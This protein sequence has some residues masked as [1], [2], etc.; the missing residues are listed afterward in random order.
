MLKVSHRSKEIIY[1]SG[2]NFLKHLV[3]QWRT[4]TQSLAH[5]CYTLRLPTDNPSQSHNVWSINWSRRLSPD[6]KRYATQG[7][8]SENDTRELQKTLPF[9]T[10]L[11]PACWMPSRKD[12][13]SKPYPCQEKLPS[14]TRARNH[15]THQ[16]QGKSIQHGFTMT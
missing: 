16:K 3:F 7:P 9:H 8:N 10:F 15:Q 5:I 14:V 13:Q 1:R 12:Q 2:L 4:K 11:W 6:L